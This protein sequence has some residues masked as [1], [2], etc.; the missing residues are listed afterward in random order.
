MALILLFAMIPLSYK[1]FAMI[2]GEPYISFFMFLSINLIISICY[3]TKKINSKNIFLT[4]IFLG[5]MGLSRQWGLLFFPSLVVL[6]FFVIKDNEKKFNISFF[7]YSF[8][9][10]IVSLGVFG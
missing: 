7:R 1:S 4:G 9:S 8:F 2:R 6:L 5:L 10:F 3:K